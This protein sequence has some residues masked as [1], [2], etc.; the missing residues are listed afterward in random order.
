MLIAD[1]QEVEIDFLNKTAFL[2]EKKE[3]ILFRKSPLKKH[4]DNLPEEWNKYLYI[5][6]RMRYF[7]VYKD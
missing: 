7:V 5:Q 3:K 1:R 6:Y 2:N 4:K